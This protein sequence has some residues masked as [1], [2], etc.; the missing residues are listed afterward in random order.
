MKRYLKLLICVFLFSF[1]LVTISSTTY[2][3]WTDDIFLIYYWYEDG[4]TAA[5]IYRN[6]NAVIGQTYHIDSPIIEG[7]E[8]DIPYVEFKFTENNRFD[9][10]YYEIES[11]KYD[12]VINYL[13]EDNNVLA[14]QYKETLSANDEYSITSP[15]ITGYTPDL[16]VV[17]GVMTE[18]KTIDVIYTKNTYSLTIKYIN[19]YGNEVANQYYGEYKYLDEYSVKSPTITGHTPNIDTVSGKITKNEVVYV[20]YGINRHRLTIY[21]N[22]EYGNQISTTYNCSMDYGNN[23]Y[24]PSPVIYGYTPDIK[25]VEGILDKD[26]VYTV[27]YY[28]N[29]YSL[30]IDYIDSNGNKIAESYNETYKYNDFYSIDSPDIEGYY[31]NIYNVSGQINQ[32]T[33][34]TVYYSVKTYTIVVNYIDENG[35]MLQAPKTYTI[36]YFDNLEAEELIGYK[37]EIN[38]KSDDNV[39]NQIVSVVYKKDKKQENTKTLIIA[40]ISSLSLLLIVSL[41]FIIKK[42]IK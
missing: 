9:V 32:N 36:S 17:T 2:A 21:Y 22:D 24:E 1:A 27:T 23:Y 11:E 37:A 42:I 15:T 31:P 34:I 25:F 35:R 4:S 41:K 30:E 20:Y 28:K 5:P 10:T 14:D 19:S 29:E 38:K 33:K 3:W 18:D 40:L 13:D 6:T 7:Y 16:E 39:E 26:Y 12:L 8:P